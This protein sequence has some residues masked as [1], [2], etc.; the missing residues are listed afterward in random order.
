M[1]SGLTPSS[2][3]SNPVIVSCSKAI[4]L[5]LA[6]VVAI[7]LH[8]MSRSPFVMIELKQFSV[9]A[10][11]RTTKRQSFLA[12]RSQINLAGLLAWQCEAFRLA[13]SHHVEFGA[14]GAF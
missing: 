12:G 7:L 9:A 11:A 14:I 2:V 1:V 13:G 3:A 6:D 4:W 8:D 10:I 5:I